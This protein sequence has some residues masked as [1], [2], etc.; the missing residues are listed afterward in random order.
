MIDFEQDR[1]SKMDFYNSERILCELFEIRKK[2]LDSLKTKYFKDIIAIQ[3]KSNLIRSVNNLLKYLIDNQVKH[4]EIDIIRVKEEILYLKRLSSES[5]PK[6]EIDE[7]INKLQVKT[8][9]NN[10]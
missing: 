2:I 10:V 9:D 1:I 5:K 7:M 4:T 8:R 3:K 6:K